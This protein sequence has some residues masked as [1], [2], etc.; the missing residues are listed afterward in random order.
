VDP[1]QRS[2]KLYF[3]KMVFK[4]DQSVVTSLNRNR[5]AIPIQLYGCDKA[6]TSRTGDIYADF[7]LDLLYSE[8]NTGSAVIKNLVQTVDGRLTAVRGPVVE[9]L[10]P[11]DFITLEGTINPLSG[12]YQGSVKV[13]SDP[14]YLRMRDIAIALVSLDNVR[15]DFKNDLF[16]LAFPKGKT[17]QFRGR[18][19]LPTTLITND[20][21]LRLN[22]WILALDGTVLTPQAVPAL[23][24]SHRILNDPGGSCAMQS[25]PLIDTALVPLPTCDAIVN[26]YFKIDSYDIA[27]IQNGDQVFFTLKRVYNVLLDTY[28][29]IGILRMQAQLVKPSSSSSSP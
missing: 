7:V 9:G 12:L 5:S 27:G 29:D 22:F 26:E 8:G 25:L 10:I 20:M 13:N 23:Q 19:D 14:S 28:G 17:S 18:V 3:T 6:S 11:G 2:L 24:M 15:Q 4:T 21:I 1:T 16:Y